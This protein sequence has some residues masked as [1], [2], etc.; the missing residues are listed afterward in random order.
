M[1]HGKKSEIDLKNEENRQKSSKIGK[2]LIMLTIKS[3]KLIKNH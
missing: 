1:N 2:K 3:R